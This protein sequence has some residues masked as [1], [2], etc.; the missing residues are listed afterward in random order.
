[1]GQ[2]PNTQYKQ[3]RGGTFHNHDNDGV[4]GQ[5]I[6]K[7]VT[8]SDGK[9]KR[10]VWK[11]PVYPFKKAHFATFPPKLIEPCILAGCPAGGV[12]LDP[13]FG[14][15]TTGVVSKTLGRRYI[16]IELNSEYVAIA[17]NRI[18][19]TERPLFTEVSP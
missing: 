4:V 10:S 1:M 12:V 7:K 16:G 19:N 3:K 6:K 17:R 11:V 14:A 2:G 8:Y 18:A 9:N 13:F 5:R 15:G